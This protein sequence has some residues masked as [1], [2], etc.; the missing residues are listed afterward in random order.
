MLDEKLMTD[1]TFGE[2]KGGDGAKR[3]RRLSYIKP[4]NNSMGP[5]QTK[6]N[7]TEQ[8]QVQ[9]FNSSCVA[10][11]TT[12]TPDVPSG[13]SF[14]V[15]TK[16]CMM[17][18]GGPSTRVLITCTIE[19]SKSSWIK[20]AIE[21][22][23][24]EG[25]VS[26]S[27]DLLAELRKKLEG[28]TVGGKRKINGKKKGGKRKKEELKDTE[29]PPDVKKSRGGIFG[30]VQEAAESTGDVLGPVVKPLFSSTCIISILLLMVFYA[31]IRVER[32]MSKLSARPITDRKESAVDLGFG[33]AEQSALWDWIDTRVGSISKEERDGRLIWNKLANDGVS[34]GG[35]GDVEEAI[36]TT[37]GK[38]KALK[39]AVE[40][41]KA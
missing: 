1:I 6:C 32:T 17:W 14:Q 8:V 15:M 9:D 28:G 5:K 35:L 31:L 29:R 20:G 38:L 37:E 39:A 22:G 21:K 16:F 41:R 23:V 30:R 11:T 3:E 12:T 19:W 36:R 26:S 24:N 10:L 25:S 4:L 18:A 7:I 33:H 40:K 34:E 27:K 2:W 13:S